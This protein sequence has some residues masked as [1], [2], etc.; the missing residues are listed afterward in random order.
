MFKSPQRL[1]WAAMAP[2]GAVALLAYALGF[3]AQRL[4]RPDFVS[5]YAA[6]RLFLAHGAGHVYQ[7][8]AQQQIEGQ[9][10]GSGFLPY[11]HPPFYTVLIA[12]LGLLPFRAAYVLWLG[13]NLA[14]LVAAFAILASWQ[15]STVPA[16]M[17]AVWTI[18][19][20]PAVVALAQ[21]QSDLLELMFLALAL[22]AWSRGHAGW[23]GILSGLALIK[24][25]LVILLPFFFLARRSGRALLGFGGVAAA[26]AGVS[27]AV[28]GVQGCF[29]YLTGVLPWAAGGGWPITDPTVYSLRGLL[30]AVPGGR[31]VALTLLSGALGLTILA[32]SWRP[33]R[34]TLDMALA[35]AASLVLA[36]YQNF[37]DLTLLALPALALTSLL[38]TGE[39]RWPAFGLLVLLLT[40]LGIE[41]APLTGSSTAVL[42]A[43]GLVAYLAG[44][45][46]AVRPEPVS[47]GTFTYAGPQP[48]RVVVLPA[49]HVEKTLRVVVDR[50]PRAE[51][52]RILLVDNDSSDR[53]AELALQL[54]IDVIKHPR[55]MGYGGSQKTLYANALLMGAE[56]VVMLHPDGQYDPA[57]VPALCRAIEEGRGDMVLGSRWLGLDPARAGMPGWKRV[58]NRFLT[59]VENHVLGLHLS[60]YHTGYRAYSRRFLETVPFA[61]NSNDFVFDTQ[62]LIQAAGFGLRVAEVPAVG[63]YF[64]DASSVNF[65]TSV[66]YGLESLLALAV[67]LG[68][69][70]GLPCRWLTPRLRQ[71]HDQE[72]LAA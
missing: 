63:R 17:A 66:V 69:R 27:L 71:V 72:P 18:A 46:L 2:A 14:L 56:V 24:P 52:D 41:A 15:R 19:F 60:E 4:Q 45:R 30:E 28:F 6:A 61:E 34:P 23:A 62:I 11:L 35:I 55:N 47:L 8:G 21:G 31:P 13:V 25:H 20:L 50:I 42:A 26:L 65:A 32:L 59:W 43:V 48:R 51:V 10:G 40:Y 53:T 67:Y 37:H 57:L 9:I 44:E 33:H 68:H 1:A 29:D 38:L 22:V 64:A 58:G 3:S 36:P 12:P 54:G 16:V 7:L 5:F 49:R 39:L 70:A